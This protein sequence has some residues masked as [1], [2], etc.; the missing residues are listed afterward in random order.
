M[1]RYRAGMFASLASRI[2]GLGTIVVAALIVF[3]WAL[4]DASVETRDSFRWVTHSADVIET[5][6]DAMIE[7]RDAES[8]Q[9]GYILTR[10]PSF[11][12]SFARQLSA[13]R[14]SMDKVVALTADNPFQ[15]ARA[16]ELQALMGQRA[17]VLREP[18][19]LAEK[20]DF[21]KAQAIVSNGHGRDLMTSVAIR[22]DGFLAEEHALQTQRTYAAAQRLAHLQQLAIIGAPVLSLLVVLV[23][24][25]IVRGI[26]RPISAMLN[27]MTALGHGEHNAR[28]TGDMGSREFTRLADSHNAMADRLE[29]AV[30]A[31]ARG[32]GELQTANAELVRS[33]ATLRA[34]GEVIELLGGMA[35]RMQAA[36]T[37]EELAQVIHVFVPRVLPGIPGTLYAHNNSRNILLPIASWGGGAAVTEGFAPDT[38]WA[39]RRGQSHTVPEPGADIVC[40]H[41]GDAGAV[42]HCEPL[43][44]GGEVIG[45]LHL[46]GRIDAEHRFRL[47]VMAENIASALFNYR[48]QRGLREQ[49]IRDPLTGLFN[50]RY[51]EE[52]LRLEISRAARSGDPLSVV[53]CDVDHFKRF[54]DEFGH[55]AGDAVLQAVGAELRTR[56]RDGDVVCRFGGEEF[57][58]IAPGST[59]AALAERV[60][61]IRRAIMDI[62]LHQ[63][64]QALGSVS[65]SFGIAAWHFGDDPDGAALLQAADAALYRAKR[66]GRN[67]VIVELRQA[68]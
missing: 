57:T 14:A 1:I 25:I 32:E 55:D 19:A 20:G 54:N 8:G 58:V 16:R 42:Y 61:I 5:M 21:D 13:T 39:L 66:E 30:A 3:A 23:S 56:F 15:N 28:I 63:A 18:F 33:S 24:V 44:A 62:S 59:P 64:G 52:S 43:L 40:G 34:R 37:E 6:G 53:M 36:R 60:E 51:L 26:R 12:D 29:A 9:R 49:S 65:M 45:T 50:R 17:A 22:V 35:H 48:L 10:H 38:C 31:T 27:A 11:A 4:V 2:V 47:A 7:L 68:A 41:I 67:R 46:K